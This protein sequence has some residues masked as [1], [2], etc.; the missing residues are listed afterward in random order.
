MPEKSHT[1]PLEEIPLRQ[2]KVGIAGKSS[3]EREILILIRQAAH[4]VNLSSK[5]MAI[6]AGVPPSHVSEGLGSGPR[7][8]AAMWLWAQPDRFLLRFFDLLMEARGLTPAAANQVRAARIAELV[9]LLI[10]E[11]A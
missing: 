1:S 5:E 2:A 7:N 6:N 4:D 8:F 11:V 10:T 9:R 3:D